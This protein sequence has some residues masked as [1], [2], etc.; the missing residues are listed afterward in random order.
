MGSLAISRTGDGTTSTPILRVYAMVRHRRRR[1]T[2]PGNHCRQSVSALRGA[3]LGPARAGGDGAGAGC[4]AAPRRRAVS[5]TFQWLFERRRRTW[6]WTRAGSV[7]AHA[8][9]RGRLIGRVSKRI[10]RLLPLMVKARANGRLTGFPFAGRAREYRGEALIVYGHTP[11]RQAVLATTLS[12]SLGC[13]VR[14]QADGFPVSRACVA[15]VSAR[16]RA[17]FVVFRQMTP[18]PQ[19]RHPGAEGDA[20]AAD[21]ND[22]GSTAISDGRSPDFSLSAPPGARHQRGRQHRRCAVGVGDGVRASGPREF[23]RAD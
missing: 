15:Q 22:A 13:A 21:A 12:I 6:C 16:A 3:R 23:R 1:Y 11:V 17:R 8:G 10:E 4:A 20:R 18:E 14:R 7:V 5:R 9:I 19:K 2:V